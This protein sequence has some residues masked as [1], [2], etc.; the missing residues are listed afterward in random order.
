MQ[1]V[2]T[3]DQVANLVRSQTC[4]RVSGGGTKSATSRSATVSLS[5]LS[6]VLQYDPAEFT[7]TALAG[8]RLDEV[9]QMLASKHQYLPFDPPLV[10]RGATLGGT[11]AAGLS[12]SGRFRYGGVRDFLLGVQFV[13]GSGEIVLAGSKVV[14]NAAGFDFPKL[15]VGS[16]GKFGV[17]TELT[18][19]VFPAPQCF[20]TIVLDTDHL[21]HAVELLNSLATSQL[22]LACLDMSCLDKDSSPQI[23]ARI[24]GIH[25]SVVER[26]KRV[27]Q[28][29]EGRGMVL[30]DQQD[31]A[32]WRACCE[33]QWVPESHSLVKAAITPNQIEALAA[34]SGDWPYRISAGG[35][36]AWLAWPTTKTSRELND[37]LCE[38][39]V[40]A[41]ALTGEWSS[42]WLGE[43][44]GKVFEQRLASALDPDHKFGLPE[45]VGA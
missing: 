18:F 19:K 4:I 36:L 5:G 32:S 24:A 28:L 23:W 37:M 25:G 12:G 22:D 9:Q 8:T 3:A 29:A 13:T 35:H 31:A 21:A 14:K 20:A 17:M 15:M 39:G 33:F 1:E 38:I 45:P 30:F 27:L 41:V 6:G 26:A 2:T 7:F 34:G 16:L 43:H 42:P 11:V 40:P 10:E 44:H